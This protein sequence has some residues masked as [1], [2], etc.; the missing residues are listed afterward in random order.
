MNKPFDYVAEANVTAS[1]NY[2]GDMIPAE[3]F[4]NVITQAIEALES[5]DKIKKA[6]Y[7]G[8]VFDLPLR[9]TTGPGIWPNMN[10]APSAICDGEPKRGE[11]ILHSIIG[12]ATECGELLEMLRDTL[13]F[14]KPFDDV[15]FIEEL[16]DS[17]WYD[18]IGCEAVNATFNDVQRTNIAKLRKRFPDK[19]T[20][21]D[22]NNR[23]LFAER[24]ILETGAGIQTPEGQA[25]LD[26]A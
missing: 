17:Q 2:H 19:F 8:R 16:G 1:N 15:N 5:L 4:N 20:E 23:D 25:A 9:F 6:L 14:Q 10:Y 22:A 3:H 11:L 12:K 21:H 13:F 24:Q 18:A 7:Y 26:K